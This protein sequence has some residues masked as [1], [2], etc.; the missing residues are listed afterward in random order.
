MVS[1]SLVTNRKGRLTALVHF[2]SEK[3]KAFLES[4][5]ELKRTA[6]ERLENLKKE[7]LDYVN[8][9]VSKFSRISEI[10]QQDEAFEKTATHKIKRYLYDGSKSKDSKSKDP[11]SSKPSHSR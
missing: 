3:L 10:D 8:Q 9:K 5:D 2:D 11:K 4:T 6:H 1:E 7:I